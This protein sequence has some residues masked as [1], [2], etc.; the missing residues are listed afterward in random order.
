MKNLKLFIAILSVFVFQITVSA[1]VEPVSI[2]KDLVIGYPD[3]GPG[4]VVTANGPA[5]P[6]PRGE[7]RIEKISFDPKS[8]DTVYH[9]AQLNSAGRIKFVVS[10]DSAR[11]LTALTIYANAHSINSDED[12]AI[13]LESKELGFNTVS[14]QYRE[15]GERFDIDAWKGLI[16]LLSPKIEIISSPGW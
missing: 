12:R 13:K 10:G 11:G 4:P 1:Q 7:W 8:K 9:A 6:K 2:G 5:Y 16:E 15:Y 3:E 14:I